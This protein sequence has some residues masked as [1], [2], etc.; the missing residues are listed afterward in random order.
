MRWKRTKV[1]HI[2]V[3]LLAWTIQDDRRMEEQKCAR[4]RN[5]FY[6]TYYKP[7]KIDKKI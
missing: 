4:D 1:I 2:I 6:E 5:Y 3:T 7:I